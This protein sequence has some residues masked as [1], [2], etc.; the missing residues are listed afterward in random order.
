MDRMA[1]ELDGVRISCAVGGTSGAPPLVLVHGGNSEAS[2]WDGVAAAF[3]GEYRIYAPELRGHGRSQWTEEYSYELFADDLV[4]LGEVLGLRDAIVVG[5]SLGGL[6]A[7]LAAQ[8]RPAWLGRLVVEDTMLRRNPVRLP[9]TAPRP[10]D[11][12]CDWNRIVPSLHRQV[13]NP[14]PAWWAELPAIDVPTLLLLAGTRTP[15]QMLALEAAGIIPRARLRVMDTGHFV[16]RDKPAEY[17]AELRSFFDAS[18]PD[19]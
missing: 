7:L 14:P 13:E 11:A 18:T 2:T 5:H 16:H 8:R 19:G 1:L 15:A 4:R 6:A 3:G 12:T 17:V 9:P 10:A